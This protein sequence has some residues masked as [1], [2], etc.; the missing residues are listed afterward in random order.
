MKR[1]DEEN[2]DRKTE[3]KWMD[4]TSV[5]LDPALSFCLDEYKIKG[6]EEVKYMVGQED[7]VNA[8]NHES[9]VSYL[10]HWSQDH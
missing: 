6:V 3:A 9:L 1:R 4:I 7:R 10:H 8:R 2:M 5:L